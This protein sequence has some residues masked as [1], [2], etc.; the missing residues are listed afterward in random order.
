MQAGRVLELLR[1]SVTKRKI[2]KLNWVKCLFKHFF[3]VLEN[4][5]DIGVPG[6]E[7]VWRTGLWCV[8]RMKKDTTIARLKL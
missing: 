6:H 5:V 8:M 7:F 1:G 3:L 2:S 4:F